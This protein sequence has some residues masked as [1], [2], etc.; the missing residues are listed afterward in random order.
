MPL[1]P[2]PLRQT[3]GDQRMKKSG[4]DIQKDMLFYE[5]G[6]YRHQKHQYNRCE[7][8]AFAVWQHPKIYGADCHIADV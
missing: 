3:E 6:R 7:A 8:Y 1:F 2:Y 4:G 5:Y